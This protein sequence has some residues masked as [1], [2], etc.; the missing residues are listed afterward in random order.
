MEDCWVTVNGGTVIEESHQELDYFSSENWAN[1]A[2][3]PI[4]VDSQAVSAFGRLEIR[5]TR[6]V[7]VLK[8][9]LELKYGNRTKEQDRR[10]QESDI[11]QDKY[12]LDH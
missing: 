7:L 11:E 8:D 5:F 4:I 9:K 2:L 10:L 1:S 3:E 6:P 12:T